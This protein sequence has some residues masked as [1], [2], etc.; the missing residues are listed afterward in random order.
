MAGNVKKA[1]MTRAQKAKEA[2]EIASKQRATKIA[3][4]KTLYQSESEGPLLEDILER[5]R[6]YIK[7]HIKIA[8]DGVGS[9]KT[10]DKYE[11]N[12][13]VMEVYYLTPT[14][15]VT[16]LDKA[17]GIQEIIDTIERLMEPPKPKATK[18]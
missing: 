13:D 15:R 3:E 14:E 12:Q 1:N 10:G 4:S 2:H 18:K 8:Q 7:Y 17:A 6:K 9:R 16:H 5:A 11:N